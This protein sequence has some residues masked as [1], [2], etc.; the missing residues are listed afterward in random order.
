MA[1]KSEWHLLKQLDD[2]EME[3]QTPLAVDPHGSAHF[4]TLFD[5]I[6]ETPDLVID[7]KKADAPAYTTGLRIW[8][9]S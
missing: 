6:V 8:W 1:R 2:G 9:K 3:D 7:V 4:P 5:R